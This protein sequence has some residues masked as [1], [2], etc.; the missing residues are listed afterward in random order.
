LLGLEPYSE[1]DKRK[2]KGVLTKLRVEQRG[3]NTERPTLVFFLGVTKSL[4][5]YGKA[6]PHPRYSVI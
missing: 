3:Q 1:M 4:Q 2:D 6:S 5:S